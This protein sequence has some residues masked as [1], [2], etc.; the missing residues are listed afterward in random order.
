MAAK[1]LPKFPPKQNQAPE[2]EE[3]FI[4]VCYKFGFTAAAFI[5]TV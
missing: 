4:G 5:T 3:A 1:G 2:E